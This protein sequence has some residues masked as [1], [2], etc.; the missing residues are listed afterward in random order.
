[1]VKKFDLKPLLIEKGERVGLYIAAGLSFLLVVMGL[2]KVLGSG[3]ASANAEKLSAKIGELEEKQRRASPAGDFVP[4]ELPPPVADAKLKLVAAADFPSRPM[5]FSAPPKDSMRQKPNILGPEEFQ[6]E[7]VRLNL[8]ALDFDFKDDGSKFVPVSV[9]MVKLAGA[10]DKMMGGAPAGYQGPKN[11]QGLLGANRGGF[12]AFGN[13]GAG[14]A[15]PMGVGGALGG[16]AGVRG[17][18]PG[19]VP[20]VLFPRP[21]PRP[22]P[23]QGNKVEPVSIADAANPKAGMVFAI[24]PMPLR[25]AVIVASFP[26]KRQVEEFRQKLRLEKHGD[27]LTERVKGAG[28]EE[29][30]SFQFRGL[31]IERATEEQGKPL[32]WEQVSIDESYK[33]ILVYVSKQIEKDDPQLKPIKDVSRGLVMELPKQFPGHTYPNLVGKLEQINSTLEKLNA[34]DAKKSIVAPSHRFQTDG[35]NSFDLGEEEKT[36]GGAAGAGGGAAGAGG[37][38]AGGAGAAGNMG[39]RSGNPYAVQGTGPEKDIK[40]TSIDYCLIRFIDVTLEPGKAYRYRIKVRMANPNYS[41]TPEERKDTYPQFAKE[42][43]LESEPVEVPKT[44]VVPP[45]SLIYAVDQAVLDKARLRAPDYE[46]EAVVQIHRWVDE[47]RTDPT[48]NGVLRPVGDWVIASRLFVRRGEYV[49]NRD[50]KPKIPIKPLESLDFELD[51]KSPLEFGDETV[52]VDFEG[53][54]LKPMTYDRITMDG[55]KQKKETISDRSA[56]ELLMMTPEGKLIT[57]VNT[58][59]EQNPVRVQRLKD[60][61]KHIQDIAEKQ[62]GGGGGPIGGPIGG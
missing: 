35:F 34:E 48:K 28:K 16:A 3:S 50:I 40:E 26:Y 41:P 52:L 49:R 12:G 46:K 43:E 60:Y 21:A 39:G 57:R 32:D 20:G 17:G 61:Q 18:R 5:F 58:I 23:G 30:N 14:G 8:P 51:E 47:Y 7:Y 31:V 38:M 56:Q 36:T 13:A 24:R 44:V 19:G 45:D 15:A 42:K 53:G 59:D 62:K 27:V 55:E 22:L 29:W 6:V 1:M 25:A 9:S 37:G 2:L 4:K 10:G 33:R 11:I 54:G